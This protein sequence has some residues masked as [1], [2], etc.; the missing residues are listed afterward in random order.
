MRSSFRLG[1]EE[2][3]HTN[4]SIA[5]LWEGAMKAGLPGDNAASSGAAMNGDW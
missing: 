4:K 3:C 5:A 1:A 2:L